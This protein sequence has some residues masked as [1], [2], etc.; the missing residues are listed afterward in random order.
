MNKINKDV[1]EDAK[2][3]NLNEI[4]RNPICPFCEQEIEKFV[5]ILMNWSLQGWVRRFYICPH[6]KK[7]LGASDY[8]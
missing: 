6:C 2:F 7:I 8:R 5:R 1:T 3:I 4:E